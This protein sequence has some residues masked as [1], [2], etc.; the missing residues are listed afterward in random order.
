MLLPAFKIK[1][2]SKPLDITVREYK[3]SKKKFYL[4][5]TWTFLSTI[6]MN[7]IKELTRNVSFI[8]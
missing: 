2:N 4:K 5:T 8:P 7:E 1:F 3:Y 6:K